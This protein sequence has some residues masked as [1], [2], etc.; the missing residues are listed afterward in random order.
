MYA[1]RLTIWLSLAVYLVGGMLLPSTH[2]HAHGVSCESGEAHEHTHASEATCC[3]H[4]H[5]PAAGSEFAD[6]ESADGESEDEQRH[7]SLTD[8]FGHLH[9]CPLC[10]FQDTAAQKTTG[11]VLTASPETPQSLLISGDAY[12]TCLDIA[13]PPLRGPPSLSV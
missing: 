11:P 7:A 4:S 2:V 10:E 8:V 3:G 13:V 5:E 12:A 6:G 9:D 1:K